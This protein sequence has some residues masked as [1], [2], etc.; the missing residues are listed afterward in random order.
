VSE[1]NALLD[2][3]MPSLYRLLGEHGVYP[4]VGEKLEPVGR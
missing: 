2:D 4:S 1:V 3:T